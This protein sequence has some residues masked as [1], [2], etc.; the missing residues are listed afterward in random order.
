VV[1]SPISRAGYCLWRTRCEHR[2]S[3]P[4]EPAKGGHE[5]KGHGVSQGLEGIRPGHRKCI[6]TMTTASKE[7]KSSRDTGEV[8]TGGKPRCKQCI[9]LG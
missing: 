5:N 1:I 6:T 2:S 7:R 8:G 9:K 4:S 3:E